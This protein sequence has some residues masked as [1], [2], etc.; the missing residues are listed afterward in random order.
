MSTTLPGL[1]L[2]RVRLT[3]SQTALRFHTLGIWKSRSWSDLL[4]EVAAAGNALRVLGVRENDVVALVASNRPEWIIADLAI[5]GL[6]ARTL[7]IHPD[8]SP[9]TVSRLVREE[10]AIVAIVSDEEQYDKIAP[11]R[12]SLISLRTI[13]VVNTRGVRHVDAH[14]AA[15]APSLSWAALLALGA[16][17]DQWTSRAAALDPSNPVTIEVVVTPGSAELPMLTAQLRTSQDL[18]AASD[19]LG[20]RLNAHSGD[21]LLPIASFAEPLERSISEVLALRLGATINIGEGGELQSLEL[22]AVQPTIAHIPADLLRKMY[23]DVVAKKPKRGIRTVALNRIL[24]GTGTKSKSA[25]SDLR[26][27]RGALVGLVVAT[28]LIHGL[29]QSTSGWIRLAL[30]AAM[31][32]LVLGALILG[33]QAVRPFVRRAYGLASARSLL[34]GPEL[35]NSTANFL[36][37]LYLRPITE[38]A[39]EKGGQN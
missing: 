24:T 36:G 37:A 22:A 38:H 30:I 14:V 39:S 23:A 16:G 32:A 2:E 25:H 13:V 20:A 8:F 26:I 10:N 12:E 33:G 35:E 15:D 7:A 6:G 11:D 21:E 27:T 29:M 19:A 1:L 9:A 4:V 28:I 34:T 5:Q 3:P 31:W 18:L 17:I